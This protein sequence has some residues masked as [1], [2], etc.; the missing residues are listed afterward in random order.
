MKMRAIIRKCQTL[1]DLNITML[2]ML[3]IIIIVH[4][5]NEEK[6]MKHNSYLRETKR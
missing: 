4:G 2:L 6:E 1:D 5:N 3:I